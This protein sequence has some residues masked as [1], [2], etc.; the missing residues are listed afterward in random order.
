MRIKAYSCSSIWD[1]ISNN[2]KSQITENPSLL[3]T[4]THTPRLQ[5]SEREREGELT[6]VEKIVQKRHISRCIPASLCLYKVSL[7]N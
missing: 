7:I 5:I 2:R 4:H 3:L 6:E 1:L